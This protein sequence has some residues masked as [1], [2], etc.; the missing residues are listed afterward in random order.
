M[1]PE[2]KPYEQ[3]SSLGPTNR[4]G[5]VRRDTDNVRVPEI[6][7]YDI[8]YAIFYHLQQN[9]NIQVNDQ[10]SMIV[11]PV[12]F[13]TAEKWSQ[14]RQYGFMRDNEKKAIAPVIVIKRGSITNDERFPFLDGNLF[15]PMTTWIPNVKLVQKRTMQMQWDRVA[16]Q[17]LTKPS[18][19]YYVMDIPTYVKV[20]YE[21]IIW[22]DLM[23]QMNHIC[24]TILA[25]DNH[26]WGD[27]HKFRTQVKDIS[28]N[29]VNSP[30]DDRLIR[31]TITLEVDGYLRRGFDY[32]QTNFQKQISIKRVDFM[33]E[34]S[35]QEYFADPE[36]LLPPAPS[37]NEIV[38]NL[39][40]DPRFTMD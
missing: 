40:R 9:F 37:E 2:I 23:E 5:E 26:I 15:N 27:F 34:Q 12:M 30:G 25:A 17:V 33:K 21:L 4:A 31:S 24:H 35:E 14:I 3:G 36:N 22:T 19:E 8:D 7:L 20:N 29:N 18:Y 10:G 39:K 6:N 28:P 16:G 13:S 11:V 38:H 32:H 1:N